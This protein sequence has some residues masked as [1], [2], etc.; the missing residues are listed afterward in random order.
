MHEPAPA[1]LQRHNL[2]PLVLV[3]MG[4]GTQ[5]IVW[6]MVVTAMPSVVDDLQAEPFLSWSRRSSAAR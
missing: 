2:A 3:N 1:L 5:A 4:V 6:F